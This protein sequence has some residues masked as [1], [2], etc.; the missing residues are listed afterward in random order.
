MGVNFKHIND[1]AETLSGVLY[2]SIHRQLFKIDHLNQNPAGSGILDSVYIRHL[3]SMLNHEFHLLASY[4]SNKIIPALKYIY[5]RKSPGEQVLKPNIIDLI[6]ITRRKEQKIL[7]LAHELNL[8]ISSNNNA[9]DYYQMTALVRIIQNEF[10]EERNK[11]NT[12]IQN[13]LNQHSCFRRT[14]N[15]PFNYPVDDLKEN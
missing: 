9:A 4:D 7:L 3:F 10:L 12:L 13:I 2:P 11:W 14:F 8:E 6:H 5:K 1:S 15:T